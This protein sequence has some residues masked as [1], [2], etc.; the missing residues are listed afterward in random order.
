MNKSA[1]DFPRT[2]PSD[3]NLPKSGRRVA[4]KDPAKRDQILNGAHC[5][6]SRMGFDAASMNDITREANVSKGTI[7]VYFE[8]KEELFEALVDRERS[9]IF[10][11][12]HTMLGGEGT[13]RDKM[14]RYGRRIT[15]LIAS[16]PVIQAQRIVIGVS[17]RMPELGAN[18]YERGP[19]R[20]HA[21]LAAFLNEEIARGTF[22]IDDVECAA[23]QFI[24]LCMAGIFRRRIF[25]HMTEKP[26]EATIDRNVRS[27]IEVFF[28]AYG[29]QASA[30]HHEDR[31]VNGDAA[32]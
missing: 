24:E 2:E 31:S 3:P 17:E 11:D 12:V 20:G 32:V 9:L 25:G 29:S 6:F 15:Q 1:K 22:V 27:A 16:D 13:A 4:G 23:Y 10:C 26:D 8:N 18:F 7:Y 14:F 28:K 30:S 5:V 21:L 19:Q